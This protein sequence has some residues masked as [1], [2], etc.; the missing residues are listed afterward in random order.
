M[1]PVET[2]EGKGIKHAVTGNHKTSELSSGIH[3]RVK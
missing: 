2:K 3:C 1:I